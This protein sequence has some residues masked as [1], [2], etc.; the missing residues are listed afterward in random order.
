MKKLNLSPKTKKIMA[1]AGS[2]LVCVGVLALVLTYSTGAS[3]NPAEQDTSSDTSTAVSM[4]ITGIESQAT[5]NDAS[6]GAAFVPS[7]GASQSAPL[8]TPS[9]PTSM[10]PKPTVE[11]DSKD[12][13]QPTNSTL[14]D[15]N[16]KPTYTTPPKATTSSSSKSKSSS[17]KSAGGSST[18][19]NHDGEF[20]DPVFGWTKATGGKGT[21]VDG[22]GDINKQ[23]GTMD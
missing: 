11:G 7:S 16:K 2:A 3:Q 17:S 13:K 5:I 15:K 4:M 18:S 19:I 22:P 12:G 21:V 9:K 20:Y 6:D 10:P 1:A 23:V 8:T 14:T